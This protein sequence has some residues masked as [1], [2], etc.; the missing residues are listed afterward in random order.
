MYP[1][2]M[3]VLQ[4]LKKEDIRDLLGKCWLTHDGMWFY[5]A[6]Q[7]LGIEAA[8]SLNMAAM[9]SLAPIEME[10]TLKVLELSREALNTSEEIKDFMIGALELLAPASIFS[11]GHFEGSQGDFLSWEWEEGACFAYKGLK[12]MGLLDDYRCGV[13]Y[14]IECWLEALGIRYE[15]N[16]KIEKC[17][18]HE[19]GACSGKIEILAQE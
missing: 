4:R 10:R 1:K 2:I 7:R 17:I 16:P 8:N 5:H 3:T 9:G 18:M 19:K 15:I 13:I 12:L 6:S 14:R 11:R